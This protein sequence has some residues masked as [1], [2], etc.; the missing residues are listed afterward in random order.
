MMTGKES[1]SSRTKKKKRKKEQQSNPFSRFE[2]DYSERIMSSSHEGVPDHGSAL[3]AGLFVCPFVP[4][5]FHHIH[6]TRVSS[7]RQRLPQKGTGGSVVEFSL[8]RRDARVRFPP[9]RQFSLIL[10]KKC[11]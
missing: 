4:R 7:L 1:G 2:A 3:T 10:L 9:V 6:L 5:F 8:T 11:T